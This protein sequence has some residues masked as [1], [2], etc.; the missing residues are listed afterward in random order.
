MNILRA[1]IKTLKSIGGK[2]LSRFVERKEVMQEIG[3]RR[4]D[5]AIKSKQLTPIKG[6]GASNC[7]VRF[8]RE[9]YERYLSLL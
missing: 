7:K 5:A 4:Y 9:Q 1:E 8:R 2:P 6:E 3:R